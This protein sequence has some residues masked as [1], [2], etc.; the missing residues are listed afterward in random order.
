MEALLK[1]KKLSAIDNKK[2]NF[3]AET[4]LYI[5]ENLTVISL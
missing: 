2:F 1:K 4:N 5:K 3:N